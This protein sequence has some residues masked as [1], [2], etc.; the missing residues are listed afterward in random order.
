M[1]DSDKKYVN[2]PLRTTQFYYSE[3]KSVNNDGTVNKTITLIDD[4]EVQPTDFYDYQPG[5]KVFVFGTP[6]IKL[7][8]PIWYKNVFSGT[9]RLIPI[10]IDDYGL[11][12]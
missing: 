8:L 10:K 5:D 9:P 6:G 4:T 7:R 12:N 2:K 11:D 3:V 1:A